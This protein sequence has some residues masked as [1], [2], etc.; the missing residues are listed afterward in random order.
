MDDVYY[1]CVIAFLLYPHLVSSLLSSP[2]H[3]FSQ[4]TDPSRRCV[5]RNPHRVLPARQRALFSL[6][7]FLLSQ[8]V[9]LIFDVTDF[10]LNQQ[11]SLLSFFIHSSFYFK[12]VEKK[13]P[14][15]LLH[16]V[17]KSINFEF[18]LL[19][20]SWRIKNERVV[21]CVCARATCCL[22]VVGTHPHRVFVSFRDFVSRALFFFSLLPIC[23]R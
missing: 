6:S 20:F 11:S 1:K 21:V 9:Y 3:P 2:L 22:F 7:L 17:T 23:I 8:L 13:D 18:L 14:Q 12:N 16:G 4:L 5:R 15:F 10:C 19:D